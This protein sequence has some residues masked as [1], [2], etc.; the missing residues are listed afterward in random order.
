MIFD[1]NFF[2]VLSIHVFLP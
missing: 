1:T 2:K